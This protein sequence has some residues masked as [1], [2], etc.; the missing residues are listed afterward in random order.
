MF[1]FHENM[2]IFIFLLL[3][4]GSWGIA[5]NIEKL[6]DAL[7]FGA[8]TIYHLF[9]HTRFLDLVLSHSMCVRTICETALN[10]C[11]TLTVESVLDLSGENVVA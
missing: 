9:S 1:N 4:I 6:R 7:R 5:E 11:F 8:Y 3:V 10:T 2:R